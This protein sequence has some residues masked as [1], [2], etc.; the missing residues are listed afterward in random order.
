MK[1]NIDNNLVE[2]APENTDEAQDLE[3]LWKLIVDC[4]RENK[5]LNP[6]G[7]YHPQKNS[8][9]RFHIEDIPAP[10]PRKTQW[11][12]SKASEDNTFYCSI[13]NKYIHI[14]KD[15]EIPLCCGREMEPIE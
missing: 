15:Q 4:V 14:V 6:V 12:T 1:I 5:K 2:L 8:Q 10:E 11:S 13:C 9:A 7:E 3:K